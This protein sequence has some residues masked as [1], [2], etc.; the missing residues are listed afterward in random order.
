MFV[1]TVIFPQKCHNLNFIYIVINT[2]CQVQTQ[3]SYKD[4]NIFQEKK[5]SDIP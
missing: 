5:S 2:Y 4:F 3:S 1:R